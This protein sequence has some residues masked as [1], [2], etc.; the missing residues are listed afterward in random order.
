MIRLENVSKSFGRHKVLSDLSFEIRDG[1]RVYI[2]GASG[3]GKT[4][5]IRIIS[6]L[7]S[8]QGKVTVDKKVAVMF[9]ESRLFMHLSALENVLC[10]CEKKS[11]DTISKAKELL[12]K[13]ELSEF[14]DMPAGELSGGM[15]QRVALARTLISG[16]SIIILDEPFSALDKGMKEKAY[17]LILDYCKDERTLI[18]VSHMQE[19]ADVLCTRRISVD[20]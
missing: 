5:L 4:T 18:L 8:C 12:E 7:E 16:R 19:D 10:V 1:E 14:E 11:E 15:A 6:G 9:Q 2:S 20:M 3:T 13:L 17:S